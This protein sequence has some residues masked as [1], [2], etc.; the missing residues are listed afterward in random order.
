[1]RRYWHILLIFS[2]LAVAACTRDTY[3]KT[4]REGAKAFDKGD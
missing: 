3:V 2:V 1:M 4:M